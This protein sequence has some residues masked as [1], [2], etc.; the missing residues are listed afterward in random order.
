[1]GH[2]A[3]A[4][5]RLRG[6]RRTAS[7]RSCAAARSSSTRSP[8]CAARPARPRA[9]PSLPRR[10]L[11]EPRDLPGPHPGWGAPVGAGQRRLLRRRREL[12]QPRHPAGRSRRASATSA[13]ASARCARSAPSTA[14]SVPLVQADLQLVDGRLKGTR[15]QRVGHGPPVAGRRPRQHRPE[16]RRHRAGRH[17]PGRRRARPVP[18]R[19]A[20]VGQG[21]RAD[22][23]RRP[24]RARRRCGAAVRTTLDHRPADVRPE[25][26]VH[27]QLP[28]DGPVVLAWGDEGPARRSRSRARRRAGPATSCT[29]SR[30]SWPSA[31]RPRSAST[32]CARRSY[33]SDAGVLQQGPVQHQLRTR[34]APSSPTGRSRVAGATRRDRAGPGHEH[35]GARLRGPDRADRAA[36]RRSRR[37]ATTDP[38]SC[39]VGFDGLPE[40]ELF[41]LTTSTWVRLPHF[42]GGD[43]LRRRRAGPVRRPGHRDGPRPLRQRAGADSGSAS[44][45]AITGEVE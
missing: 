26:R 17:R 25:L 28:S 21:R 27:R 38:D 36:R 22:D 41:D 45:L 6:R 32:C 20:A 9:P 4:H 30:P 10:L 44:T 34:R 1:M 35:R 43:A 42:Q 19:P 3:R 31:A 23:V 16:A 8:S 12:G 37:R 11:A 5:R 2:D 14:V 18:V 40:V 13:S 39:P 29:S 15:H 33:R 24:E 7:A